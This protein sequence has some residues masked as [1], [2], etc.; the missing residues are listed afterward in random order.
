VVR[1]PIPNQP[2]HKGVQVADEQ[3][4]HVSR[5]EAIALGLKYYFGHPCKHGHDGSRYTKSNVCV[6]CLRARHK[7]YN[8]ERRTRAG[9]KEYHKKTAER[10]RELE[11][12]RY[13]AD[14]ER[15]RA[16]ARA[17]Y[18][19]NREKLKQKSREY[20]RKSYLYDPEYRKRAQERTRQWALDNPERAK[21]NTKVSKHRRR[22]LEAKAEGTFTAQDVTDL[23]KLQKG[24]CAYCTK[25][26]K[27]KDRHV[28]HIIALSKGGPNSRQNL[29][30]TCQKCNL[31]KGAKDPIDFARSLGKLL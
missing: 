29:Q 31:E 26:L 11:R 23:V 14:P 6:E 9:Y 8:K 27:L 19:K 2:N 1:R 15:F 28:D 13:A 5:Q 16:S 20:Y 25:K 21:Y 7:R 18:V 17:K 10:R 12:A 22:A 4:K 30:L 24:K 3:D